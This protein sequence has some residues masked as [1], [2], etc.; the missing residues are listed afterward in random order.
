MPNLKKIVF[1]QKGEFTSIPADQT[2]SANPQSVASAQECTSIQKSPQQNE[3]I[4]NAEAN[5]DSPSF[6]IV[7]S[8]CK[9]KEEPLNRLV[10]C[11]I[12]GV[13]YHWDIDVGLVKPHRFYT[14]AIAK[15][16]QSSFIHNPTKSDILLKYGKLKIPISV[17]SKISEAR[18]AQEAC[19]VSV[20]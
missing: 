8:I 10:T 12:H 18:L 7:E 11:V 13:P 2:G 5:V 14:Y 16:S 20:Y 3:T 17:K 1:N 9:N 6:T 15:E 4:G 19:V